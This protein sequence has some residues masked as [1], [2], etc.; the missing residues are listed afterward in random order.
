MQKIIAYIAVIAIAFSTKAQ[1]PE[2]LY[3]FMY[4]GLAYKIIDDNS[5]EISPISRTYQISAETG[6]ANYVYTGNETKSTIDFPGLVYYDNHFYAIVG[7]GAYAFYGNSSL[8]SFGNSI[9]DGFDSNFNYINEHAFQNCSNL[10]S[11]NFPES[12]HYIGEFAFEGCTQLKNVKFG[13]KLRDKYDDI[14]IITLGKYAFTSCSNLKAIFLN[15][16]TAVLTAADGDSFDS[17]DNP[18]DAFVIYVPDKS[19]TYHRNLKRYNL[20][21]Y[22]TFDP[23]SMTYTG[24]PLNKKPNFNSNIP[25]AAA[26]VG[27]LLCV[28]EAD[29]NVGS[30]YMGL[31]YVKINTPDFGSITPVLEFKYLIKPTILEVHTSYCWPREYGEPNP[32]FSTYV[33][34]YVNG[35]NESIFE[36]KPF[37]ANGKYDWAP[38]MPDNTTPVGKYE[39]QPF[40]VLS[41]HNYELLFQS[42]FL[43][44]TK[45]PIKIYVSDATRQYGEENPEFNVE[46]IGFKNGETEASLV[47]TPRFV[48]D[49]DKASRPGCYE[50]DMEWEGNEDNYRLAGYRM[51]CLFI[52]KAD[53]HIT[54]EQEFDEVKVGDE[55]T[56][57]A[58]L[59]S[60]LPVEYSLS[61]NDNV[62]ELDGNMIRFLREGTVDIN[63]TQ[64]GDSNHNDF[65]MFKTAY[66]ALSSGIDDVATDDSLSIRVVDHQLIVKGATDSEIVRVIT[67]SGATVYEGISKAITLTSGIYVVQVE[68][69]CEKVIVK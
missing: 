35:E 51:G 65:S 66:V 54:W 19:V 32:E 5:V 22:G 52:T 8:V 31:A 61:N 17:F 26:T 56:L 53:Q 40:A 29:C 38:H 23:L 24:K 12:V 20:K 44:I 45:A 25:G 47:E 43:E 1:D 18:D 69:L 2:I 49:A 55:I 68:S 9:S 50:I 30:D 34:G 14:S 48:V 41:S 57:N 10:I 21:D 27:E 64:P 4:E 59:S 6:L 60:G 36:T 46:Y 11:L 58:S 39:I 28:N 62:A 37:I 63:A 3:D 7:I 33:T 42:S 16:K 15:Y 67:L 13:F